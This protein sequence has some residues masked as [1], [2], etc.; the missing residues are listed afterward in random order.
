VKYVTKELYSHD[1]VITRREAKQVMKLPVVFADKKLEALLWEAF[2]LYSDAMDLNTP[3]NPGIALG[4]QNQATVRIESAFIE[5]RE[6]GFA[7]VVEKDVRKI[8]PGQFPG[9]QVAGIGFME[10]ILSQGWNKIEV[11]P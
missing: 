10:Q 1:Y 8:M 6:K 3:Y 7:H 5:S 4:L 9:L 2:Q 11:T